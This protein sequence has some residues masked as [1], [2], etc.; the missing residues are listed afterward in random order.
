MKTILFAILIV[1]ASC[2]SEDPEPQIS[3][4]QLKAEIEQVGRQL[5][6]HYA[7]GSGGNQSAW[8]KELDRLL[9]IK[10]NKVNEAKKRLC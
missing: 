5:D 4:E 6:A 9:Y 3:C 10:S 2:S 7:K 1:L 8:E